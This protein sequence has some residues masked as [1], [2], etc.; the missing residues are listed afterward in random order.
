MSTLFVIPVVAIAAYVIY[1]HVKR[2]FAGEGGC[3]GCAS[4]KHCQKGG[5]VQAND[6]HHHN[7]M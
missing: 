3:C 7:K 6:M 5:S 2:E 4:Q 1:R